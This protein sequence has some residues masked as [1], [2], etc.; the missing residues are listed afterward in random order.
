MY[1]ILVRESKCSAGPRA[2][3]DHGGAKDGIAGNEIQPILA[4]GSTV[5]I[6][7]INNHQL[8]HQNQ[9]WYCWII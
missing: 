9:D 8:A 6:T 1:R 4:T 2:L 5:N 7:G 3:V